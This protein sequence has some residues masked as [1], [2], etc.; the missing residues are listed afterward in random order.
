MLD[1]LG[2]VTDPH[3]QGLCWPLQIAQEREAAIVVAA[4]EAEPMPGAIETEKWHQHHIHRI[5]CEMR[6]RHI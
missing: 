5:R 3:Q 6:A 4:A 2:S 1:F